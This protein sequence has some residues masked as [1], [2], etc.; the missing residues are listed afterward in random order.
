MNKHVIFLNGPPRCGKDSA[1]DILMQVL[2]NSR[3][4]KFARSLKVGTHALFLAMRDKMT[5]CTPMECFSDAAFESVKD[6]SQPEFYGLTPREAY[7]AV[8]ELLLK[9]ALGKAIF[10]QILANQILAD[11]AENF[12]VTDSGFKSEALSIIAKVGA[13]NCTLVRLHRRGCSFDG[14]SRGYIMLDNVCTVDIENNGTLADL[15]DNLADF[16]DL[17]L[18]K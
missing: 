15:A 12:I 13:A 16:E 2:P 1:G 4:C 6:K 14:D 3:L 7:I 8:S 5:D 10:G 18:E 9:P 17:F 11:R